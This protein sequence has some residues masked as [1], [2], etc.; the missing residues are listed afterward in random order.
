MSETPSTP[1]ERDQRLERILAD[2]LHAVE[3]G[4][5]SDRDELLRQHPDLAADLGSFFRNRDA[6]QRIADPIKQ[7][8]PALPETIGGFEATSDGVGTMLRYFGDYELLEE[9]ARGGMGVVYKAKQV[10]LNRMVGLKMILAGQFASAVE[11]QRFRSEAEA[12]ANLDHPNIVP[13]YEIGEHEGQQYFSMKLIGPGKRRADLG[14][15]ESVRITALVARAVH[16]A[17]QRGILHRDLKPGN[18]LF[19]EIGDPHVAD[20]GLAKRVGGDSGTTRSGAIVGTPSYMAPEQARAEKVLTT[21]VDVYSLGAILYEWLTGQPPFRGDDVLTTLSMVANDEPARPRSLNALIDRDLETICLKCLEKEPDK[22]FATADALADELDRYLAGEP[23]L[24]RPVGTPERLMRWCRRKPALAGASG[25]AAFGV[26][27]ALVVFAGAFFMVSDALDQET[28]ERK[29]A[30]ASAVAAKLSEEKAKESAAVAKLA[31]GKAKDS[32]EEAGSQKKQAEHQLAV[33]EL[34]LYAG[35]LAQAQR[36]WQDNN[37]PRAMELLEECQWNLR[38]VEHRHLSSLCSANQ[39]SAKRAFLGHTQPVISV[40][41]SADGKYI[42]SGT[43]QRPGAG[44]DPSEVKIWDAEK[45]VEILSLPKH[46][47]DVTSV[48]FSP[49]RKRVLSV[50]DNQLTVKVS[51]AKTGQELLTFKAHAARVRSVAFSAGGNRILSGGRSGVDLL[52]AF[53][54]DHLCDEVKV[55]NA[56]KGQELLTLKGHGA[57]G[58]VAVSADGQRI[59]SGSGNVVMVWDAEKRQAILTFHGHKGAVASVA[60]SADGKRIV[61]GGGWRAVQEGKPGE[62]KVWDADT[63]KEIFSWTGYTREVRGVAISADGKRVVSGSWDRTVTVWDV[64][65]G[66]ELQT[67]KGASG[68]VALSPDGKRVA[69]ATFENTVFVWDADT[70]KE[71]HVLKGNK[72]VVL[73]VA[74]SADGKRIAGG[75]TNS[76]K[77]WDAETGKETQAITW[78]KGLHCRVQSV[79]FS[80]DGKRIVSGGSS[81]VGAEMKVWDV[82][83]GKEIF[84]PRGHIGAVASVA[85]S[86]D[87]KNFISGGEDKTVK[88]WDAQTGKEIFTLKDHLDG[89]RGVALSADSK[90]IVTG[91]WDRTAKVWDAEKAK[92]LLTLNGHTDDVH[93]VAFSSDGQRIL[94]G[95]ADK[96]VKVWDAQTG[97]DIFTL[98]GHTDAVTNVAFAADGKHILSSSL[99]QTVKVWD[100]DTGKEIRTLKGVSAPE[101]FAFGGK[102]VVSPVAFGLDGK[103]IVSGTGNAVNAWDARKDQGILLLNGH[104]GNINS[105][106]ISPDGKRIVSG[107]APGQEALGKLLP[108]ELKVWDAASGRE[109]LTLKGNAEEV[110]SVAFSPDGKRVVSGGGLQFDDPANPLP[111]ELKVW[112]AETGKELRNITGHKGMVASVAFSPDGE[113]ILSGGADKTVKVWDAATGKELLN[114]RGHGEV[115]FSVAFSPDGKRIASSSWQVEQPGEVK[116]WDAESGRE[117]L[118]LKGKT[119]VVTSVCFSPDSKRILTGSPYHPVAVW[120]AGTGQEILTL[121]ALNGFVASATYSADGKRILTASIDERRRGSEVKIWDADKGQELLS[122]KEPTG[123]VLSVAFS[124]DG[125]RIVSN[126]DNIVKVRVAEN[127]QDLF[128]LRGHT[129]GVTSVA[130][131]PDGKRILSGSGDPVLDMPAEMKVWDAEKGQELLSLK[132]HMGFVA[133]VAYSRDGKRILSSSVSERRPSE[134]KVWDAEKGHELLCVKGKEGEVIFGV[135]FDPD[136]KRI[137]G[138]VGGMVNVWDAENGK[139]LRTLKGHTNRVVSVAV[140]LDGKRIASGS[141]D[142]TVKVWDADSGQELHSLVGH[143]NSVKSV[144][145]SRDG[146]RI[147]SGSTDGLVKLWNSETGKELFSLK[148]DPDVVSSVAFSLDGKLILSGGGDFMLNRAGE[149]KVWDAETGKELLNSKWQTGGPVAFSPNGK[150]IV[151]GSPFDRSSAGD[152]LRVWVVPTI[153]NPAIGKR[154]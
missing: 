129:G 16:H 90:R 74:F 7:Q 34:R 92:D 36:E 104:A 48:A 112:D 56:D 131:S 138:G 65:Q 73:G 63:G 132:G 152:E 78:G 72:D 121:K 145:F 44:N 115:V 26:L 45:G 98:K 111:G 66:K 151:S 137:V 77:V 28:I 146:K 144:A 31:E 69:G 38:N 126:L 91:G 125:K 107:S 94:S 85:S 10:S 113:R 61:S 88:V 154:D 108:G 140:S 59:V 32:A 101:A 23:I 114:L 81:P 117:L 13:I 123:T 95:S 29:N 15:K 47:G 84:S 134:V 60:L 130:F 21:A 153:V 9:I 118:S 35:K 11:V 54:G 75:S 39:T 143:T 76:L 49:D 124:R 87:G 141:D 102:Q 25:L 106:A 135:A 142:N 1:S 103:Q 147:V 42:V 55:W 19:D 139:V 43:I 70:G 116:V 148:G 50:T 79:A 4:Q 8:A 100:A 105:I 133:T 14:V 18:I 128:S 27:L 68:I 119:S 89:V 41:I 150:R 93:T 30:T 6:M 64:E 67:I 2:Y 97:K 22:R 51:D 122:L 127:G 20:F 17:H 120:D 71:L 53:R 24:A 83:T 57:V 149:V 96:T 109:L 5:P 33:A 80:A 86:A 110:H 46:T 136:G 82:E 62:V 37:V 40:A 58:S 52:D 3:A 12:A 99:D